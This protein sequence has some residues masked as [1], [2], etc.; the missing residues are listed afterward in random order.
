MKWTSYFRD[1][2]LTIT[3]NIIALLMMMFFLLSAGNTA[4]TVMLAAGGWLLFASITVVTK[5]LT[6]RRYLQQLT[7]M[8]EGLDERYLAAE[9]MPSPVRADD[10]VF[11]RILKLSN[12]SMLEHVEAAKQEQR[13]YREYIETWIHE[14][15]TPLAALKLLGDNHRSAETRTM[16]LELERVNHYAEQ[17]L[18]YA[19]SEH[20]ARDYLIRETRLD[21]IIHAA[22]AG[23]KQLL[24]RNSVQ[25]SMEEC[26][27][28]VYTDEKWMSFVLHQ[29]IINAVTYS[30]ENP[31]ILFKVD[32]LPDRVRLS[33]CDNGIG[34]P[35]S[36]LPRIF[37]KGFTGTNGRKQSSSTGIGLFLVRRLCGKLGVTIDAASSGQGTTISLTF[38]LSHYLRAQG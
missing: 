19:R 13:E 32:K 10:K 27:E 15:K 9:V 18:Y 3:A 38:L 34:I 7:D 25:I 24:L 36:D 30:P 5:Y 14:I 8:V 26:E 17:A 22:I 37:D 16:M 21:R 31:H 23:N 1:Q 6:R 2:L 4:D 12:K 35:A 20:V 33:V 29:L 11:H 28:Y